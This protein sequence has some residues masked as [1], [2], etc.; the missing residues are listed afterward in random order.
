MRSNPFDEIE[1]LFDRLS[2]EFEGDIGPTGIL[3]T[4]GVAVDVLDAGSEFVVRADVPGLEADEIDLTI[5]DGTL[6]IA[7]RPEERSPEG[8]YLR[9]ERSQG[10]I[11]RRVRLPEPVSEGSVTAEYDAGVLTVRVPKAAGEDGT[12]IEIE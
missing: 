5:V 8:R 2:R 4:G 6:S 7:A 3:D 11:D 1:E 9:Q 10:P 12:S